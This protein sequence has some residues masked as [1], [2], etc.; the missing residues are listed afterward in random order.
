MTYNES[1]FVAYA[2]AQMEITVINRDGKYFYLENNFTLEVEQ[3]ELYKITH[4]GLVIS[5]FDDIGKLCTFIK[6]ATR[7]DAV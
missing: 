2:L 3:R 4:E 6:N 7:A 1:D 5:P